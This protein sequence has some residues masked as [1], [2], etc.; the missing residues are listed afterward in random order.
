MIRVGDWED[1]IS[2][3][4]VV[5]VS[6][7]AAEIQLLGGVSSGSESCKS[8]DVHWEP[9]NVGG[10]H[11]WKYEFHEAVN[12]VTADAFGSREEANIF[13]TDGDFKAASVA[14]D[15][16]DCSGVMH[17]ELKDGSFVAREGGK[18]NAIS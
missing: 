4:R 12:Y 16:G 1:Y 10:S 8:V 13:S 9:L 5:D 14:A 11:G 18:E 6:R 2:T 7:T 17:V 3:V 15:T